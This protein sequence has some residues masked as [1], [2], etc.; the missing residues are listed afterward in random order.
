MEAWPHFPQLKLPIQP[1]S[2]FPQHLALDRICVLAHADAD[3]MPELQPM[4]AGQAVQSTLR[5]TAG[6]R[7]FDSSLLTNH[8]DFCAKVGGQ[9]PVYQ[10]AYPHR[11]STLP[12]VKELLESIC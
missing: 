6:A 2:K 5:H 7:L 4:S 1:G 12:I 10:L 11:K 3:E 8:L 9:I